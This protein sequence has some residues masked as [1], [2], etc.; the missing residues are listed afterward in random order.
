MHKKGLHEIPDGYEGISTIINFYLESINSKV[1]EEHNLPVKLNLVQKVVKVIASQIADKESTYIKFDEA[2]LSVTKIAKENSII[3]QSQFFQDLISEGLLTQNLYWDRD[4]NH[5]DGV[6][7][8]YERFSDHLVCSYLLENYF[9]KKNPTTS[10]KSGSRLH[11][12]VE[13]H[14][15]TYFNRGIIEALSI[16]LPEIANIE[17]FEAAT[18]AREFEAV[19]YAFVDSIIWRKKETVH[20]K[21]KDYINEVVIQKLHLNDYFI[22]TI[23][24]VTSHPNHYFNSDFLH[25]HLLRFSMADRDAWWTEF[26]HNQYP[27][28]SDEISSIRRMIDWAWTDDK[29]ENISNEAIRLMCQT[30][31]WFLTSTNRTLRD[32]AT[33]AII[34]LL[35]ER[36]NVLMQLLKTFENVND[37]YILQRL[38][39]IA[40]GC[41]VRTS[42][43]QSLKELGDYIFDTVFNTKNVIP[44]ILLRDYARGI[45]EFAIYKGHKFTFKLKKIR[46]PF[47]SI[48]PKEFPSKE[49][50]EK[51]KYDSKAEGF[52]DYYWSL[53]S[54]ISSM[55]TNA[56]GQMYGDF[57]RYTFE[58][59]FRDWKV[60]A[61]LLSNLAVKWI[62]EEY[63]YDVEKHGKFDRRM[64]SHNYDRHYVMEE[65][66]GKKYQWI[67]FY[68]LLARVA[69]NFPCCE[70]SY[71]LAPKFRNYNGPWDPYVRD[72]DPTITIKGN[73]ENKFEKFWWNTVDYKNWNIT[74]K[75][76]VFKTDDLPNPLEMINVFDKEGVEWLV[77]EMHTSWY[78]P[79]DIG[80]DKWENP[81]KDL[82]YQVRSYITQ[83]KD[84]NKIIK[85]S[86][87]KNFMGRWMPE[88]GSR[89]ELFSREYYWSPA[90]ES[91]RKQDYREYTWSEIHDQKT[92]KFIGK[93][94]ITAVDYLWEE[95]FDA[96]KDSA[97]SFYKPTEIIF[98]L[99]D[100]QYSKVE[101]QLLSKEGQIVCFDP[102]AIHPTHSCLLVRKDD[103]MQKLE[104]NDLNIFW[105][106]LGEKLIMG[107]DFSQT[108]Y[109]GR[110]NISGVI[111]FDKGQ[112]KHV[113]Y[114]VEE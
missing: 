39:A 104:E 84:H 54:I 26:I 76:W 63:G 90:C 70:N 5:F 86:R 57:G 82:W 55:K 32:S 29:R 53:D 30:L 25:R 88:S 97:I 2:F 49:D 85:W 100:L 101:G 69:D 62:I 112:L 107:G 95:Q 23:L 6:Y 61:Q 99:L 105:T 21:L 81:H 68:N 36:I 60:N 37:G 14:N 16:Q 20:E 64:K 11:K 12:L 56:S 10:F 41:A 46:P 74:N 103:L 113:P 9:D 31:F 98:N 87:D 34:C 111:N 71:S 48:L 18:H 89:H 40:Y 27:G 109:E 43:I 59:A 106:V 91:F 67:A 47:K 3:D 42:N 114:F 77:L 83:K 93:V 72:I 7:I 4:G 80:K 58:S 28:Y 44:D 8:S 45:I 19:A 1:S 78:E 24:L 33:K 22:N 66:I 17:L 15:A 51:Y 96:S 102:C 94:A 65:R 38:Y 92:R 110:L 75:D 73:P 79:A 108:D 35:E 52:K 50:I 13:N